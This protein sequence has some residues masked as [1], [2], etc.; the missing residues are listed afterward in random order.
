ML[1][2]RIPC[3]N[4]AVNNEYSSVRLICCE[5]LNIL[6]RQLDLA[7]TCGEDGNRMCNALVSTWLHDSQFDQSVTCHSG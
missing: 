3:I 4:V 2:I 7:A 5:L 1:Q 6:F